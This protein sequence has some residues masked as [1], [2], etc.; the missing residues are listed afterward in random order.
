MKICKRC[1]YTEETPNIS[2]DEQGVCNY[3]H[4]W[5]K[6]NQDYPVSSSHLETMVKQVKKNN[7]GSEY[8]CVVGISGGCDSS[9][10]LMQLADLGL[11]CLPVHWNNT[12]NTSTSESN[13]SK[14]CKGLGLKPVTY[15]MRQS[16]YDDICRA[17][18]LAGTIDMDIANDIALTKVLYDACEEYDVKTIMNG[19]SFRT[20]GYTPL[21]WTYMDGMYIY[22]VHQKHGNITMDSYPNLW[23]D[24]FKRFTELGIQRIRPLYHMVFNKEDAKRI[25]EKRFDWEWYGG[26]HAENRYTKFIGNYMLFWKFKKDLRYVEYSALIRDG[27]MT[28]EEAWRLVHQPP[29]IENSII[30]LVKTRLDLTGEEFETIIRSPVKTYH[31]YQNY[32]KQF[33]K[34]KEYWKQAYK[35]DLVTYT[36]VKKYCGI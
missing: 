22:D 9:Y 33:R 36:F 11:N 2:F 25:L 4:D 6:M 18:L 35:K 8:D 27:Q 17:F 32:L 23:Y 15:T 19:H 16:E 14:V 3:C 34:D 28:R 13:M 12:W 10:M 26:H 5:D 20:E 31:D 21:G 24:D 1:I 7:T 29:M 30:E